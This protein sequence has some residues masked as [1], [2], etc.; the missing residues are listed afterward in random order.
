[1]RRPALAVLLCLLPLALAATPADAL[2]ALF[3]D[4]VIGE[5]QRMC[6]VRVPVSEAAWRTGVERWRSA[7]AAQ[8]KELETTAKAL[9][10]PSADGKRSAQAL[11][12]S[13]FMLIATS[14]ASNAL[15]LANDAKAVQVCEGWLA[16]IAPGGDLEKALPDA[17]AQ[18]RQLL[19]QRQR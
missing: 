17:V 11:A 14:S 12:V 2:H 1:V 3:I 16:R 18:A 9:V 13:N 10:A 8:L 19:R 6:Q 4:T 15:A 7:N 5:Q